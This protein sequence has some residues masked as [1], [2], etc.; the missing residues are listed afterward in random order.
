MCEGGQ[1]CSELRVF[2]TG[3]GGACGWGDSK[4]NCCIWWTNITC[5]RICA[6]VCNIKHVQLRVRGR[7]WC[8]QWRTHTH[9]NVFSTLVS[10]R[11]SQTAQLL[12]PWKTLVARRL[13]LTMHFAR[14]MKL[15]PPP[16]LRATTPQWAQSSR[17]AKVPRPEAGLQDAQSTAKDW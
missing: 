8:M 13:R 10:P 16:L 14:S 6:R 2:G 11:S 17:Q 15:R 9:M 4:Y 7:L 5:V 12:L 1:L 3:G